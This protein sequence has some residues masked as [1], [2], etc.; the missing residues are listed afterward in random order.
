MQSSGRREVLAA[1]QSDLVK[2]FLVGTRETYQ[3][4]SKQQDSRGSGSVSGQPFSVCAAS[5]I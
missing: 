1:A 5:G 2:V 3:K 4:R